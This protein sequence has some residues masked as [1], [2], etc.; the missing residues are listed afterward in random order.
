MILPAF[1]S[2]S[3]RVPNRVNVTPRPHPSYCKLIN[4]KINTI[5]KI[6]FLSIRYPSMYYYVIKNRDMRRVGKDGRIIGEGQG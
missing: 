5:F 4:S 2:I 3:R 1:G 6:F